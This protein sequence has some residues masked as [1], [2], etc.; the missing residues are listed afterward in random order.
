MASR[1]PKERHSPLLIPARGFALQNIVRDCPSV[2]YDASDMAITMDS[3]DHLVLTVANIDITVDYYTEVLGMELF[4]V[5]GR[6]ALTFGE[7]MIKLQQRG[8]EV[9]PKAAHP[10]AGAADLCFITS[11]PLE[12]VI[13]H[14]SD[15]K[16]RIEEGPV[17]RNGAMGKMRSIYVRDPDK[18]LVEISN[19]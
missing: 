12:E 5:D 9:N 6:K 13:S 19:Y 14:L 1:T 10:T 4:S 7:Q 8:H 3:L 11:T 16:V 18:N 17:E 2:E 15:Q